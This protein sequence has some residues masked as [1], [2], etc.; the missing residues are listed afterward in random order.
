MIYENIG[1]SIILAIVFFCPIISSDRSKDRQFQEWLDV[2]A[3]NYSKNSRNNLSLDTI[4]EGIYKWSREDVKYRALIPAKIKEIHVITT[5]KCNYLLEDKLRLG[6]IKANSQQA[7]YFR[8]FAKLQYNLCFQEMQLSRAR[9]AANSMDKSKWLAWFEAMNDFEYNLPI[10]AQKLANHLKRYVPK[11]ESIHFKSQDEQLFRINMEIQDIIDE[12]CPYVTKSILITD[13]KNDAK[14][15]NYMDKNR[16]EFKA[17]KES[18]IWLKSASIC[19][20]KQREFALIYAIGQYFVSELDQIHVIDEDIDTMSDVKLVKD[21]L[22]P[23]DLNEQDSI[24]LGNPIEL[25]KIMHILSDDEHDRQIAEQLLDLSYISTGSMGCSKSSIKHRRLLEN[26]YANG[27]YPA[28]Q[29][30]IKSMNALQYH[31][32]DMDLRYY[33]ALFSSRLQKG[34]LTTLEEFRLLFDVN[35]FDQRYEPGFF[36]EP[37]VG[38]AFCLRDILHKYEKNLFPKWHDSDKV[39]KVKQLRKWHEKFMDSNCSD[40]PDLLPIEMFKSLQ[41]LL[42]NRPNES[43]EQTTAHLFD[44]AIICQYRLKAQT[45]NQLFDELAL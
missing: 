28:L 20:D 3:S 12:V 4:Y 21:I 13:Y 41:D 5:D 27:K 35:H 10:A 40:V 34:A 32:C 19:L 33:A 30:Y 2:L 39:E 22:F 44:Y 6:P 23:S 36:L 43:I 45:D 16:D 9:I 29:S 1:L 18:E 31:I 26:T 38:Y 42:I 8:F 11:L 37:H 24:R 25:L 15:V 14:F 17:D 7:R